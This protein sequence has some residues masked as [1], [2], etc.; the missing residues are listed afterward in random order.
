MT[1]AVNTLQD[2]KPAAGATKRRR[3][4]GRGIPSG[5]GKTCGRGHRGQRCRSGY[6]RKFWRE[7]GQT[8]MYRRLPKHQTNTRVNR[9]IFTE[10]NLADLQLLA[11]AGIKEIDAVT[12]IE[13]GSLKSIEAWGVK[14]LGNGELK[15]AVTVTAERFSA[16]AKEAIEKAGG[17]AIVVEAN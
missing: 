11:D 7:G 17:K 1:E 4:V 12:L 13:Q 3:R 6:A 10:I 16:S 15:S 14:I 8:P 9:K 5:A 2:L